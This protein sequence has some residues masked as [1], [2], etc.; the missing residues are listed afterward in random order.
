MLAVSTLLAAA[1]L[2]VPQDG[3]KTIPATAIKPAAP[4]AAPAAAA[5]KLGIGD[6]APAL[7][8]DAWIKGEEI[9]GIEK[10]KVHV[11]EFWATWCGPCIAAM[12]HLS[13]LQKKHPEVVV[14]SV[15][16]SERGS[17][18]AAKLDKVR[19][20]V[21][22]K[23]DT[24]GYRVVYAGDREKMS[25][26]WMQASGQRG[27][28]CAFIVDQNSTVA[29]IGHPMSMDAPLEQILAGKWDIDAAKKAFDAERAAE[30]LQM[31]LRMTMRAAAQSGD[32]TEA[33]ATIKAFLAENANDQLKMQLVQ[34]LAG[35]MKQPAEAWKYAREI[36][37]A[38]KDDAMMM[39]ALAW[40][41]VDPNGGIE[42]PDLELALKCAESGMKASGGEN[43]A[44]IDTLARVVFRM[45]DV[46]RAIELQKKA[47]EKT[48]AGRMQDE[49]KGTLEEYQAALKKA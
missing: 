24:M 11:I 32:Y 23:G 27:I 13:E 46:P 15:A 47:I 29:W 35:P 48:E 1:L 39:N 4:Q 42:N 8:Y 38:R 20:F 37:D 44:M 21:E 49:M 6:P 16:S 3:G 40:M 41:M 25:M 7:A 10:G 17:D 28:P 36:H 19:S 2:A 5:A 34:I 30:E 33:V 9:K 31:K 45:G 22:G 26:P 14:V 12:P 18:E 43:G